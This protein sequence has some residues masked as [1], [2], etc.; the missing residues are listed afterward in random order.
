MAIGTIP[1]H[2]SRQY[3]NDLEHIRTRVLGM[4]G[5]VEQQLIDA[6][7]ALADS[8]TELGEKVLQN[9]YK[10]NS[11][12]VAIDEDCTNILARRQPAAG[13]LRLVMAVAKTITDL[14]RVGD[15]SEKIAKMAIDLAE[16]QGPREYYIGIGAMGTFVRRMVHDALDAFARMDTQAALAV[17]RKEPDS[18]EQYDAILRQLITYMMEDPRNIGG[19]M[20][21][22]WVARAMERIGDH[23][24]NICESVIY[25]VE[26]KDVRH[27]SFEEIEEQ[28]RTSR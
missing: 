24:R 17:A 3:D 14:E 10:V 1:Q 13:D 8:N 28:L 9:E 20:D 18:D 15:E 5:L 4:G 21:A 16:K 26:G 11:L 19:A 22:I 27:I 2:I 23:A 7:R 12:E 25:F 6:L